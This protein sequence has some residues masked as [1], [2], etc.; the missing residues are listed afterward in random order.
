MGNAT[1]AR[2]REPVD[3]LAESPRRTATRWCDD[4]VYAGGCAAF[5]DADGYPLCF[6]SDGDAIA[7]D[8]ESW[9]SYYA[10]V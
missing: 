7:A 3:D 9:A 6:S 8:P 4:E 5:D 1:G 10:K 2:Y